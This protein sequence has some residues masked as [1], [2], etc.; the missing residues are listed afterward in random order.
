[1]GRIIWYICPP[2]GREKIVEETVFVAFVFLV[3]CAEQE[4]TQQLTPLPAKL[5]ASVEVSGGTITGNV[6]EGGLHEYLGIP[7][8]APPV[9]DRRWQPPGLVI[10]WEGARDAVKRGLPCL[11]PGSLSEFYDRPYTE[12]SEDCLTLNVWTRAGSVAQ[13]L[14]VMVWIHGGALVMG[15]GLDYD[16]APLTGRGVVLVTINYRLGPFGFFAHPELSAE[17]PAGASGNQGFRDQIA[18]LQWVKDNIAALGVTQT[19]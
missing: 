7:Y 1:M 10:A 5:G 17:N 19:M 16:G 14:P 4:G 8:A 11:Q 3:S 15:S 18:A 13:G 9:G 12:T 2:K 6:R